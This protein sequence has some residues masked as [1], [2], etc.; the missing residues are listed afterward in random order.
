L[1]QMTTTPPLII[2]NETPQTLLSYGDLAFLAKHCVRFQGDRKGVDERAVELL[3]LLR[4]HGFI[5]SYVRNDVNKN[6]VRGDDIVFGQLLMTPLQTKI[7]RAAMSDGLN[8]MS[9]EQLKEKAREN[10]RLIGE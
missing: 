10:Y 6:D 7:E 1:A 8:R 2:T 9:T 5:V 3:A 4:A